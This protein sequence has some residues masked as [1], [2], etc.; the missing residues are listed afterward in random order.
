MTQEALAK[1]LLAWNKKYLTAESNLKKE[2]IAELF[3]T[4]FTVI[5]NERKYAANHDNYFEFLNTFRATIKSIDYAYEN[6]ITND[7]CAII[8]MTAHI[9]R[10][11]NSEETFIAI[12]ILKFDDQ[13]KIILWQEV[14]SKI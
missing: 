3:A 10:C 11:D 12:L 8:P 7:E 1:N 5:A 14:Y 9:V 6:I 4:N 2:N 13:E